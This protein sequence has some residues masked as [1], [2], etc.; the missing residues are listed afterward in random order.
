MMISN[1]TPLF[2]AAVASVL[3]WCAP[4]SA[5]DTPPA[6]PG[7]VTMTRG[8][9]IFGDAEAQLV[10]ALKARDTAAVDRLVGPDFEQRS[11]AAPGT[12][13]PREDWLAQA[14]AEA[15]RSSAMRE[16][17]VHDY[18][19][20]AIVSFLWTR[21]PPLPAAF[22]VDVWQ[23]PSGSEPYQLVTRYMS[24]ASGAPARKGTASPPVDPKR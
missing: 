9:K 1:K 16:M 12:P 7:V 13:L 2:A 3:A 15:A 20:L 8:M 17:A 6:G 4:A 18:G 11:Q 22:V 23:R 5:A 24:A 10:A 19:D 14:P 21:E